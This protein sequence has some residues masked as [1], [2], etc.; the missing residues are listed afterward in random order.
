[1]QYD[2]LVVGDLNPDVMVSADELADAFG[3][4]EQI[5]QTGRVLLGGSSAIT[6]VAA[7]RLGLT[8]AL[9]CCVGDDWIGQALV[10]E[11]SRQGV[12]VV[13]ARRATGLPTSLTVVVSHGG[14]RASLTSDSTLRLLD[15][16]DI[17]LD[18]VDGCRHLHVGG[19]FLQP[20]LWPG[21]PALLRHAKLAGATTSVD[22]N[23][24]PS[25]RWVGE[26][27]RTLPLVDI[28]LPNAAE[29]IRITGQSTI[30]AAARQLAR[31]GGIV[32]VK[33]GAAGGLACDGD[34]IVHAAGL[35]LQ[36]ADATG[37]GDNFDAGFIVGRLSGLDMAD[38][39]ALAVACGGLST[40]GVGGTGE[41]VTRAQALAAA[42]LQTAEDSG[43]SSD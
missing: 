36:A 8:V 24:D 33:D 32:A 43:W 7:A 37:A 5:V 20:A 9:A 40:Q 1:L 29:A 6:A 21:L 13:V 34:E 42:G 11:V 25:E 3:Q 23:W 22:P 26:L 19:Y 39:L 30:E 2:L 15:C 16:D 14:D 28:F 35:P 41:V 18:L 17:P 10:D 12:K 4:R 38:S 27:A 31:A